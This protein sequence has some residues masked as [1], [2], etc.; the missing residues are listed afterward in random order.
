M[1]KINKL[2]SKIFS[3]LGQNGA[4][5]G[6]GLI[7]F[8]KSN[9]N[10]YVVSADMS[11]PV[12]LDRF[13]LTYP[14]NFFNVGIAEQ[15]LIGVA[16]GLA[17]EGKKVI[18][19]AQA[20]FISMRSCEQIRQYMGY[21]SLNIIAV[22]ISSGFALTYFGNTHYCIEDISIMKSIPGV[23][24]LSPSDAG[25]AAKALYLSLIHI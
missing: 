23:T 9:L 25:Q 1:V 15:N 18:A 17:S 7:D 3:K 10:T 24:I 22:G 6:I 5:F 20:C 19:N 21:M 2:N 4:A 14:E 13:K 16:A 12:G 8:Q 11:K